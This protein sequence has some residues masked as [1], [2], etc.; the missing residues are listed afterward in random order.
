M[1]APSDRIRRWLLGSALCAS[2]LLATGC[3][4][5]GGASG[6]AGDP[7]DDPSATAGTD[8]TTPPG[9]QTSAEGTPS[10]GDTRC[11]A[12]QLTLAAGDAQ[13]AAG[14]IYTTFVVANTAT[15]PCTLLGYPGV[16]YLDASGAQVGP[17]ATRTT[18]TEPALVRL[19]PAGTAHF[20]VGNSTVIPQTGCAAPVTAPTLRMYPPDD[21]GSLDV[22]ATAP[23]FAVCN[24]S[25][26]PMRPGPSE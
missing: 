13:G 10:P 3:T 14:T 5:S 6:G 12:D 22:S 26:G 11:R 4:S 17:A 25:V 19:D 16:S 9:G 2:A 24:P 20:V 21:T 18:T 15:A 7:S 1:A 8:G 23:G